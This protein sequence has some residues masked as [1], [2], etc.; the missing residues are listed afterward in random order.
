MSSV[1]IEK[2]E[3]N[4]PKT[5]NFSINYLF[6]IEIFLNVFFRLNY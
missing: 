5:W 2:C 4:D 1:I 6:F 3:E